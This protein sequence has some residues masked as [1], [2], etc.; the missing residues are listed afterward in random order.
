ME[1]QIKDEIKD[2]LTKLNLDEKVRG[3][4]LSLQDFA[5]IANL[6]K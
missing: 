4:N 1:S 3:E 5:N 2:I 6:I